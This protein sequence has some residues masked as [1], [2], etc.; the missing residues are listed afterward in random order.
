MRIYMDVD[1]RA[2]RDAYALASVTIPRMESVESSR[3]R[4]PRTAHNTMDGV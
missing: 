3:E 1:V 4:R 2:M